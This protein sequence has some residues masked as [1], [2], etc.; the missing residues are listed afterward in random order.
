MFRHGSFTRKLMAVILLTSGVV[1]L[2]TCGTFLV[3][4]FVSFRSALARNL[5]TLARVVAANSTAALAFDNRDDAAEVL[6]AFAA[7]PHIV[8]AALY[9]ARGELF[10]TYPAGSSVSF[11]ASPG[12]GHAFGRNELV[13]YEAVSTNGRTLG[14]LYLQS[15]LGALYER[16]RLYGGTGVAVLVMS[17]LVAIGLSIRLQRHISQPVLALARTADVV[18]REHDYSVRAERFSDD[19]LGR[20]T[21]AFNGMLAHVQEQD[22]SLREQAEQL[23]REVAERARAEDEVRV[24]NADLER[25]VAERTEALKVANTELESFSYSVSHDLRAPLRHVLGFVEMLQEELRDSLTERASRYMNTIRSAGVEMGQLIDD[26]LAFSRMGR[27]EMQHRDVSLD[28]LIGETIERIETSAKGRQIVWEVS[29]LPAVVADRAMLRQVFANLLDNAVKYTRGK[30]PAR[31]TV[32]CLG[33]EHDRLVIFVRD[34][35]AGFEMRYAQKLFG[36]FQRLHRS[37][38]FEGTGIGLATVQRIIVRHGGR[39]W[40]E[41]AVGQGACFYVTLLAARVPEMTV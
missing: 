38:E 36:V 14:T 27:T 19:E 6:S 21:D 9:D 33:M 31:I 32:G 30:D 7:E 3:Y 10:A 28:E 29:P 12:V 13:L 41:A 4:D 8:A 35:G 5:S 17:F 15:D 40:A 18:S 22:R 20:L 1:L 37:E 2:L 16:Y 39:V 11:P 23:R 25:R 26:L 24:L 34:N